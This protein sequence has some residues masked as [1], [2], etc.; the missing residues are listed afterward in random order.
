MPFITNGGGLAFGNDGKLY[1]AVGE[2]QVDL[3]HK[4]SIAI[5]ENYYASTPT[6][7]YPLVTP[8]PVA[9]PAA[10]WAYGLRNPF[11]ISSDPVSEAT[12]E[13]RGQCYLGRN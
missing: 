12:C 9:Q 6:A 4:T 11:T 8:L 1:V 3:I 13:R 7:L 5:L 10:V 2:N